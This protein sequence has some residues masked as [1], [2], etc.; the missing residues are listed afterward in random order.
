MLQEISKLDLESDNLDILLEFTNES[1][2]T[3]FWELDKKMDEAKGL[4]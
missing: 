2:W 4:A 3:L 1:A